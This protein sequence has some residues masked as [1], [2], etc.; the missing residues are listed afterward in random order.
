MQ[1]YANNYLNWE[2]KDGIRENGNIC[3]IVNMAS[4]LVQ[5]HQN[6]E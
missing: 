1:I 5:G 3:W 2:R 4:S 6:E